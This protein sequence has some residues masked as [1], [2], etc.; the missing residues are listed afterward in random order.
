M[1]DR[2]KEMRLRCIKILDIEIVKYNVKNILSNKKKLKL[3]I[4]LNY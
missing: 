3:L 1:S 2:R 4:N